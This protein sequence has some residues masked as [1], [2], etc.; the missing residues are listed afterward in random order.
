MEEGSSMSE[1]KTRTESNPDPDPG[2]KALKELRDKILGCKELNGILFEDEF[3]IKFL[4]SRL[5]NVELTLQVLKNY[6]RL[7]KVHPELFLTPKQEPIKSLLEDQC[8]CFFP[9]RNITGEFLM[10]LRAENWEPRKYTATQLISGPVSF[11]EKAALDPLIQKKGVIEVIDVKNL[12][13]KQ[14]LSINP[15]HL[16]LFSDISENS[17]PIRYSRV[18]IVNQNKLVQALYS[19]LKMFFTKEFKERIIFNDSSYSQLHKDVPLH[20]L[21]PYLGGSWS[22]THHPGEEEVDRVAKSVTLLWEA[23]PCPQ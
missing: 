22:G 4:Y 2:Q 11:L 7:R 12:S 13:W 1:D 14:Y 6:F 3:L 9:H 18:H 23:Y 5:F 20:L 10:V 21:P 8:I 17:L 19:I 16:K 15:F